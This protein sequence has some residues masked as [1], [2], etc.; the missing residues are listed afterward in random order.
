MKGGF[1]VQAESEQLNR[2]LVEVFHDLLH[3]EEQTLAKGPFEN[4]SV[5]EM[6]VIEAVC[7]GQRDGKN[8]MAA[9]AGRL[10]ISAGTLTIAVKTLEQKGYLLRRRSKEDRRRVLVA[11]TSLGQKAYEVHRQFHARMIAAVEARL[12]PQQLQSLA[13]ALATLHLFFSGS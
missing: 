1:W 10:R 5:S 13:Q 11:A 8:S 6:H 2:F 9:L 7:D 4:L 12:S 3:L